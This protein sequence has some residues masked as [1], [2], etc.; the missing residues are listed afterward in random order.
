MEK[1]RAAH[2]V[3]EVFEPIGN[4]KKELFCPECSEILEET[5]D[6]DVLYCM[7]CVKCIPVG[8]TK[9]DVSIEYIFGG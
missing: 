9:D 4:D 6:K 5:V 8:N 2:P 7:K 3:F 1:S